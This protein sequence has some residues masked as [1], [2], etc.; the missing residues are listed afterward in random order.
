MVLPQL[1]AFTRMSRSPEAYLTPFSKSTQC[2]S[3]RH[4]SNKLFTVS[5]N[6]TSSFRSSMSV[7]PEGL[8]SSVFT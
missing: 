8:V 6:L 1:R 7:K 5:W 4:G 3:A 2:S